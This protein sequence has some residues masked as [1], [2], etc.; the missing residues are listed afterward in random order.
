MI[1]RYGYIHSRDR[2]AQAASRRERVSFQFFIYNPRL[3]ESGRMPCKRIGTPSVRYNFTWKGLVSAVVNYHVLRP[4]EYI[5]TILRKYAHKL[6]LIWLG[7]WAK[8]HLHS[9]QHMY[10][11][12]TAT[13]ACPCYYLSSST[14]SLWCSSSPPVPRPPPAEGSTWDSRPANEWS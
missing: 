14:I 6:D 4:Y 8:K 5:H 3:K 10:S 11:Y 12:I 7:Q 13:Y 9:Q 1:D 2:S